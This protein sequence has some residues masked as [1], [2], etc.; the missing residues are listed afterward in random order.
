M[1]YTIFL[2]ECLHITNLH[3]DRIDISD[4]IDINKTSESRECNI[5]H[6]WHFSNKGFTFEP[7]VCNRCHDFFNDVYET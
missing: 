5:Y 7:N 4:E 6:Y 3:F 1:P 2:N